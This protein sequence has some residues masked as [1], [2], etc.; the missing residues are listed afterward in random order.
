VFLSGSLDSSFIEAMIF[1]HKN[2]LKLFLKAQ[3][4]VKI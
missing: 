1:I 2:N 4:E 3:T